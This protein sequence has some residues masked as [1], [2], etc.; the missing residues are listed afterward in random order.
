ML[1]VRSL[2]EPHFAHPAVRQEFGSFAGPES[3]PGLRS[4]ALRIGAAFLV[5]R[6]EPSHNF[7]TQRFVPVAGSIESCAAAVLRWPFTC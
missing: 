5:V 7:L 1:P 3:L 6:A 2:G 4:S